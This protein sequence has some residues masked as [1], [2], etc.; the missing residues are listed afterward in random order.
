MFFPENPDLS[1]HP[2]PVNLESVLYH[3]QQLVQVRKYCIAK[4]NNQ[5][6][7]VRNP[8]GINNEYINSGTYELE[9]ATK[10]HP[11]KIQHGPLYDP[12]ME[13]IKK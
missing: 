13:R 4:D 3:S 8:E 6:L 10:R 7:Q 1:Q 9:I 5:H 11:C 2:I 12:K